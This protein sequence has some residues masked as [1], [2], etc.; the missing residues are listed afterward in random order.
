MNNTVQ[1]TIGKLPAEVM[2][3]IEMNS[4]FN[5]THIEVQEAS[6]LSSI[7]SE[8]KTNRQGSGETGVL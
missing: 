5:E 1:K 8:V 7:R 2:F 4:E 3:G 6:S